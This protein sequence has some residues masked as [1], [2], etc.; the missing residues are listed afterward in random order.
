MPERDPS[1]TP[2]EVGTTRRS[3]LRAA[4]LAALGGVGVGALVACASDAQVAAPAASSATPTTAAASPS[5]SASTAASASASAS[6]PAPPAPTGPSIATA[7][8]PVGS[9]V[10]LD[11]AKYVVTQPTKGDFKAFSSICTHQGCPV[12][13]VTGGTINCKCHG[14]K[15]SIE[16]GSV[17]N[18]PAQRPLAESPTTVSGDSV[19]VEA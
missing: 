3:V 15:F 17:V 11:D 4:G 8:V 12:A 1:P 19:Y 16:D 18:P 9:G 2:T 14:S 10:I 5:P 6:S 13:E 7:D